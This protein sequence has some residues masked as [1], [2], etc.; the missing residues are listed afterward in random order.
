MILQNHVV[1]GYKLI[2]CAHTFC[3]CPQLCSYNRNVLLLSG[4][5]IIFLRRTYHSYA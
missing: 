3:Y 5:V 2:H 1:Q 4:P